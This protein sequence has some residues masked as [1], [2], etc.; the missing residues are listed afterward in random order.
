MD[1]RET[2]EADKKLSNVH[3]HVTAFA[4]SYWGPP[5]QVVLNFNVD[6][7]KKALH[8]QHTILFTL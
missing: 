1:E 2:N 8:Y 7:T 5:P 6:P 4:C 3:L